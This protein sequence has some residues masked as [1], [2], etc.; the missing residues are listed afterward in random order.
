M[1]LGF[2]LV[3]GGVLFGIRI[4]GAS[5]LVSIGVV[6][7]GWPVSTSQLNTLLCLH[8][9]PINPVVWLGAFTPVRVLETL[10]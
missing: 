4:V 1:E 2:P 6:L 3:G 10:S 7:S 9:W 8:F 5:R